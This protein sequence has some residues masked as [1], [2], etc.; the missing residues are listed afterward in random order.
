VAGAIHIA[1]NGEG[2]IMIKGEE[3]EINGGECEIFQVTFP[4]FSLKY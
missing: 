1:S 2:K 4:E 3:M